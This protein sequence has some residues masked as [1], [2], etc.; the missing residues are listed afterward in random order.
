[1]SVLGSR[2]PFDS[3]NGQRALV[4]ASVDWKGVP[5]DASRTLPF[6]LD[7]LRSFATS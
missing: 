4:L 1:M 7:A 5:F 3:F 2:L 6:A